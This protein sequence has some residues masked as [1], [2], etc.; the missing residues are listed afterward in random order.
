MGE[1]G[2]VTL[3]DADRIARR[4]PPR[5]RGAWIPVAAVL[6]I[7][8]IPWMVWAGL[9]AANPDVT[10]KVVAFDV[11]SDTRIDVTVT[12]Q[13][14][15]PARAATCTVV[16]KAVTYD[17][18][19]ELPFEVA[20]GTQELTTQVVSVRTFKRATSAELTDCRTA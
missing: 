4:Y 16:T 2:T 9:H 7:I 20:P 11:V 13:R 17:T 14:P 12:I 10:G 1:D 8:G 3:S 18:V 6:A 15:D 5:R 19:G